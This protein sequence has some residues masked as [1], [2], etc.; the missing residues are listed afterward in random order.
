MNN[1]ILLIY[2]YHYLS[3]LQNNT[4]FFEGE[5]VAGKITEN[6]NNGKNQKVVK[7]KGESYMKKGFFTSPHHPFLCLLGEIK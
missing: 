7:E 6:E 4:V 2:S 5:E 3:G 1:Y